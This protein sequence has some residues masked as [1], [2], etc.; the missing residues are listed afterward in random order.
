MTMLKN[1]MHPRLPEFAAIHPPLLRTL[2]R[3][4]ARGDHELV[5]LA[6]LVVD[7][8]LSVDDKNARESAFVSRVAALCPWSLSRAAARA[9]RL[10]PRSRAA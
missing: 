5:E 4:Q 9:H 10:S 2:R 8:I 7:V 3:A 6:V 1:A